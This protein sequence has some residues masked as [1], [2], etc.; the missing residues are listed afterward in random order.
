MKDEEDYAPRW[1]EG[2]YMH[3]P[4]AYSAELDFARYKA[5]IRNNA[6]VKG[7]TLSMGD[8][9]EIERLTGGFAIR[10]LYYETLV[11]HW[12]KLIVEKGNGVNEL[13]D[14]PFGIVWSHG[15][16][17]IQDRDSFIKARNW[18]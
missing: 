5:V 18:Q 17:L 11:E 3:V 13:T 15:P 4:A 16:I 6:L 14:K 2:T 1:L 9:I 8:Y 12:D 10:R 7:S